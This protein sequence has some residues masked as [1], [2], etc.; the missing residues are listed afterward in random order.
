MGTVHHWHY[1]QA[2][3]CWI[4]IFLSFAK[5]SKT[6]SRDRRASGREQKANLLK[7]SVGIHLDGPMACRV[8]SLCLWIHRDR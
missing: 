1:F 3:A 6:E 2:G 8:E 4:K 7:P 5:P